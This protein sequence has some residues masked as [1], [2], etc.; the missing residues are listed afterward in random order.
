LSPSPGPRPRRPLRRL[1]AAFLV[2]YE[3]HT[4]TAYA[5]DLADWLA[6]CDR[7]GIEP[8]AAHRAHVDSYARELAEVEGRARS[9]VAQTEASSSTSPP[10]TAADVTVI[11]IAWMLMA[12]ASGAI[13]GAELLSFADLSDG[14]RN[15]LAGWVGCDLRR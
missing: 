4:R 11:L 2:G 14:L 13:G 12:I 15:W 6:F 1:L 3:G 5:R 9:T 8:L 7:H 10:T